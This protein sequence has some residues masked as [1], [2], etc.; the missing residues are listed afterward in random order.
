MPASTARP[1]SASACPNFFYYS[2]S[3]D[4]DTPM[5]DVRRDITDGFR[6]TEFAKYKGPRE[7]PPPRH[8]MHPSVDSPMYDV[9]DTIGKSARKVSM[10]STGGRYLDN[11]QR[12]NRRK[13]QAP[14]RQDVSPG[15]FGKDKTKA[16]MGFTTPRFKDTSLRGKVDVAYLNLRESFDIYKGKCQTKISCR[17]QSACGGVYLNSREIRFFKLG[18]HPEYRKDFQKKQEQMRSQSLI[19]TACP[20]PGDGS[21]AKASPADSAASSADVL[22]D[23][24][25]SIKVDA[26]LASPN[27]TIKSSNLGG[28]SMSASVR[29]TRPMSAVQSPTVPTGIFESVSVEKKMFGDSLGLSGTSGGLSMIRKTNSTPMYDGRIEIGTDPLSTMRRVQGAGSAFR[30]TENRFQNIHYNKKSKFATD[31]PFYNVREALGK[32]KRTTSFG[33]TAPRFPLLRYGSR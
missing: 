5:Y 1:K 23:P 11:L 2:A 7:F 18:E 29:K 30:T 26:S 6:S 9:T 33:T 31:P 20:S 16:F 32:G 28:R 17:P 4:A 15:T 25:A 10:F 22:N 8:R 3:M 24:S 13:T 19:S 21:T 14:W 27:A 12:E